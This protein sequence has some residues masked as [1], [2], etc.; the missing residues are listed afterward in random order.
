MTRRIALVSEHASPLDAPGG[1]DAGGQNVYV[2][3]LARHLA[4]LGYAVDV[5][6][7]RDDPR[8][9]AAVAWAPG[10]R[11][12]HVPAGPPVRLPK[13]EL[14]P[15]MPEFTAHVVRLCRR[16][17]PSYALL[18][19]NFWMSALVAADVR[20]RLGIPFV[21]TFH[22]LGRVR[23][24][25]QGDADRFP[26]VR[27]AVEDRVVAE[28]DRIIAECPQDRH[29]LLTLYRADPRRVRVIPCGVDPTELFPVA[30]QAARAVTGL[31]S[32]ERVVLQLGRLV[33]RKGIDTV[34]RGVARLLA[35]HRIAARLVVVGGESDRPDPALTPEIGRLARI[36]REE[37]VEG[38]VVF[39]GR[40]P[41][42][43]LRYF[44][45]AADVFVTTPWYEPFGMTP[46]EAM[47]CGTPVVGARVGGIP[48]TVVEGRTGYLVPPNDPGTLADRLA[49][50][51]RAPAVRRAMGRQGLR[52]VRTLFTWARVARAV[53]ELYEEVLTG[54][55]AAGF[56]A[57]AEELA[58]G[59]RP[60]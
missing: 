45:S 5:L 53:A 12:L 21:V 39:T 52:R 23:R 50:L 1:T 59:G 13:E 4:A 29:D 44:Y 31:R 26:D 22:A 9:P 28:A 10:V 33:P 19:A 27:F 18:H 11:I 7:R 17:R 6:T 38:R 40:R 49:H 8:L 30:R 58:R 55:P 15:F 24:A 51:C 14:L 43:A 3:Q 47:A 48:Y 25:F 34:V 20:R 16:E 56:A 57:A 41:R 54:R 35:E 46:L 32:S 60:R 37:G 2:G 42:A 36:A